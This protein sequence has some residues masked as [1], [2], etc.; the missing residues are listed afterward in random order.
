MDS[1][2]A[3]IVGK[4]ILLDF[5]TNPNFS[6]NGLIIGDSCRKKFGFHFTK[7]NAPI[8]TK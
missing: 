2:G 3:G 6:E 7:C 4:S 1:V 5:P 8:M